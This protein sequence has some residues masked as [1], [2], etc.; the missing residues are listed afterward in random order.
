MT[1]GRVSAIKTGRA[2]PD[3]LDMRITS[4][5][6]T[7]SIVNQP[8]I[9]SLRVFA[10]ATVKQPEKKAEPLRPPAAVQSSLDMYL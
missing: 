7:D 8:H 2:E 5:S 1:P 6:G 9:T 10:E 4:A 3:P